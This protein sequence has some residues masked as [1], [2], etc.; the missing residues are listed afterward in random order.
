[1]HLIESMG[2]PR[3]AAPSPDR[4]DY[5]ERRVVIAG[6]RLAVADDQPEQ[7]DVVV[8]APRRRP[9]HDWSKLRR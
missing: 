7:E 9:I 1:M 6:A 2:H 4:H 8:L 3:P 5:V